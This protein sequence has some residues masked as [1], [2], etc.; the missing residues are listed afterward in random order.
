MSYF[1][2]L[3]LFLL[4]IHVKPLFYSSHFL[5]QNLIP[6][7]MILLIFFLRQFSFFYTFLLFHLLS[8]SSC[9]S[10][11][12]ISQLTLVPPT[13]SSLMTVFF[14]LLLLLLLQ[15]LSYSS[16]SLIHALILHAL[17][18]LS[19]LFSSYDGLLPSTPAT[20]RTSLLLVLLHYIRSP[21]LPRTPVPPATRFI[22]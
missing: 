20:T 7:H 4:H 19:Y 5:M 11:H 15:I 13:D 12:D 1:L 22:P 2:I 10:I 18:H 16:Y 3:N 21:L 8:Y 14:F 17:V 6:P 9:F